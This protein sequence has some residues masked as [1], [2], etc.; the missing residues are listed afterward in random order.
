MA[1]V[2]QDFFKLTVDFV[3]EQ[4]HWDYQLVGR[5]KAT[6]PDG[7]EI[8]FGRYSGCYNPT[9]K[10][11]AERSLILSV[12]DVMY[13]LGRKL[14]SELQAMSDTMEKLKEEE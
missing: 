4:E 10:E 9:T 5:A 1:T 13:G 8:R 2:R 14:R 6:F 12:E 3:L 7:T 11:D